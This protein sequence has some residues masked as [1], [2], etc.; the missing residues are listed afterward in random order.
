MGNYEVAVELDV[1]R[2]LLVYLHLQILNKLAKHLLE[3]CQLY[4]VVHGKDLDCDCLV[5][6]KN[7]L[8]GWTIIS[9]QFTCS[10][11]ELALLEESLGKLH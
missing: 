2:V 11:L 1:D 3:N 7:L 5:Y 6:R 9:Y 8:D 4:I 10:L